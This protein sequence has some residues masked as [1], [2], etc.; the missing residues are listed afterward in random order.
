MYN[1]NSVIIEGIISNEPIWR[2][3]PV[4]GTHV[5]FRLTSERKGEVMHTMVRCEGKV[6]VA[7][8]ESDREGEMIRVVG[9][10]ISSGIL[11]EHIEFRT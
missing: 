6:A 4:V 5:E 1:L 10:L 9:R 11:A 3:N 7:M 8:S 2:G